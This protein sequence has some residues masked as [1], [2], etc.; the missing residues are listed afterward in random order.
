MTID[1]STT[2]KFYFS[3]LFFCFADERRREGN[4]TTM[5]E[6]GREGNPFRRRLAKAFSRS[7]RRW[8]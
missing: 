2:A 6:G 3:V 8:R 4:E 7:V 5:G 1:R